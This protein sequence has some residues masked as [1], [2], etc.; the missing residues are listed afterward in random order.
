[1]LNIQFKTL[2]NSVGDTITL[3]VTFYVADN[4]HYVPERLTVAPWEALVVHTRNEK[5]SLYLVFIADET[6]KYKILIPGIVEHAHFLQ[7]FTPQRT[8]GEGN[9]R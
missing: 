5:E 1:M 3:I 7:I 6:G 4:E 2:Q 9:K 8:I